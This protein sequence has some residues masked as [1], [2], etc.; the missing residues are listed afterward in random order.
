MQSRAVLVRLIGLLES[1]LI[2]RDPSEN[3][4]DPSDGS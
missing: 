1:L 4:V 3:G 2:F